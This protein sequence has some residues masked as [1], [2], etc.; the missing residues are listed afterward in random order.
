M[1]SYL[2]A[3][4]NLSNSVN[5]MVIPMVSNANFNNI[6]VIIVAVSFIGGGNSNTRDKLYHI[7]LHRVHLAMGRIQTDIFSGEKH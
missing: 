7:M 2:I 1:Y 6:S 3:Y 5:V 4:Y